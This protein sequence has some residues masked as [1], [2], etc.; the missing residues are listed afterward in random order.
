MFENA[1]DDTGIV[2]ACHD[3][4]GGT[5]VGALERI[6]LVNFLNKPDPGGVA[7]TIDRRVI[8]DRSDGGVLVLNSPFSRALRSVEIV[9]VITFPFKT[10]L[11]QSSAC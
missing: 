10:R 3:A 2:D 9:A 1:F 8:D 7:P 4:H 11:S 5:A 6:D